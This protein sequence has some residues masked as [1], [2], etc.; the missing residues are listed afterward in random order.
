[1]PVPD[2]IAHIRTADLF[3]CLKI[4]IFFDPFFF[5]KAQE[6]VPDHFS[7]GK[8]KFVTVVPIFPSGVQFESLHIHGI[9]PTKSYLGLAVAVAHSLVGG[10][11]IAGIFLDQVARISEKD[12]R[13]L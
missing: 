13:R 11:V 1:V 12:V 3:Q 7:M 10:G 5:Y 9:G 6:Q 8:K 4:K 2:I